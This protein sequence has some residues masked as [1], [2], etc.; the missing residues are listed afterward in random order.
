[1]ASGEFSVK[2]IGGGEKCAA[3]PTKMLVDFENVPTV[4]ELAV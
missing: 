4:K 3:W 2:A 1:V